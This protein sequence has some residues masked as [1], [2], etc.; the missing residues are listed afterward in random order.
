MTLS[1]ASEATGAGAAVEEMHASGLRETGSAVETARALNSGTASI[2]WLFKPR[3][4]EETT[5]STDLR[6]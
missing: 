3:A 1:S 6:R 4:C 2:R 5:G